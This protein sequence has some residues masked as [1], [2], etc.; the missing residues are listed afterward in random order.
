MVVY[1]ILGLL[2]LLVAVILIRTALF[3]PKTMPV[4]ESEP[5]TFDREAAVDALQALVQC[6]TIS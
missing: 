6:R 3:R 1:I 5:V 4:A 2:A